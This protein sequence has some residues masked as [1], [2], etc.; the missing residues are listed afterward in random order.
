MFST[1]QL[2]FAALFFIAFVIIIFLQYKKDKN[3]HSKNYKGVKWIGLGF[4]IFIITLFVIKIL[5]KN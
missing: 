5:L 4:I 3:L 1:G 2:I